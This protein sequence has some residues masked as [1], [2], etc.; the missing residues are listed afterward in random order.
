MPKE[1]IKRAIERGIGPG[2]DQLREIIYEAFAPYGV[3]L[4]ILATTDNI[5][6][7]TSE[8]RNI[9]ER[10]G[11]KLGHQG[12]VA[13]LFQKCGL[14]VF[15]KKDVNEENVFSLAEKVN[16]YDIDQDET[17]FFLSFPFANFGRVKEYLGNFRYE[18]CEIDY[19][20]SSYIKIETEDEAK[21]ILNLIDTL[22]ELDD[23][24]K[25]FGNFDIPDQHLH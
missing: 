22:E 13:Y 25:V 3:V 16:A 24:H 1:N 8:I 6:R 7:T 9:L 18:T 23:I 5:N 15:E 19:K 4:M 20:P 2:R 17:H 10:Y 11:G 14:I 12:S 21:K